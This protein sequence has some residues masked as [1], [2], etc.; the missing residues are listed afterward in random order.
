MVKILVVDDDM[1]I[2]HLVKLLLCSKNHLVLT[3]SN[4]E[5]TFESAQKFMPGWQLINT[6]E[7]YV[8]AA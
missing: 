1:K 4:A 7:K 2:L 8:K 6:I 5:D 3:I